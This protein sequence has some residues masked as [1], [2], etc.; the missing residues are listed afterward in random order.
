MPKLLCITKGSAMRFS[1]SERFFNRVRAGT[2]LIL[3]VA[4]LGLAPAVHAATGVAG[5]AASVSAS[6]ASPHYTSKPKVTTSKP[7]KPAPK[8]TLAE[9]RAQVRED[10]ELAALRGA[11]LGEGAHA[12][13]QEAVGVREERAEVVGREVLRRLLHRAA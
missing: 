7:A 3:A 10:L 13:A 12:G 11:R 1:I 2:V 8:V 5:Q 9:R 4:L 6:H